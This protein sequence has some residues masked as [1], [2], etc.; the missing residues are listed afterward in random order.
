MEKKN[1]FAVA[2][3]RT[4]K[5][6]LVHICAGLVMLGL[7]ACQG[8][9]DS[10]F[11]KAERPIPDR[12]IKKMKAKGMK[13]SSPILLRI[14]KSENT[15]ELWKQK[16]NGRYG[17][18]ESY[19]I[20]KWSG[21]LGPKHKEGDR[22]APEGFY[23]VG[24]AQLNP[25]SKYHL[26]FN[27]G[28]PNRF[29]RAHGRTG[30]HLM[31]HGACSSAGCYSMTDE[32]VEEIYSFA[33]DAIRGGQDYFQVQAYPFRM[34]AKNLAK[35]ALNPNFEFW[36]MLK[37]GSDQFELTN[38]PPKVDVCEKRYLFNREAVD[39]AKFSPR[40]KCPEVTMPRRLLA[41]YSKKREEEK[42][43]FNKELRRQK[44]RAAL[45]GGPLADIDVDAIS[46]IAKGSEILPPPTPIP[47]PVVK[48]V[49]AETQPAIASADS[50]VTSEPAGQTVSGNEIMAVTAPSKSAP[51][52]GETGITNANPAIPTPAPN[53][54]RIDNGLGPTQQAG[55]Q[56]QPIAGDNGQTVNQ[57]PA[58]LPVPTPAAR[59]QVA[60]P[61][62][63]KKKPWWQRK[64]TKVA[65]DDQPDNGS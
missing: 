49:P 15:L 38:Y 64:Q 39:D 13:P 54:A 30:S 19:E 63:T 61:L 14:Y 58:A 42:L 17:L 59:L 65:T 56:S 18:L 10:V 52:T 2:N 22:Q 55:G 29:D 57:E 6:V 26:S 1:S 20:C 31:V 12:L 24:K 7:S 4:G 44:A 48:P 21:K 41:S 46:V 43:A 23:K 60:E 32:R 45:N 5:M 8:G 16:D 3:S 25:K 36:K 33:R 37:E 53:L 34:S 9:I 51:A 40:A 11:P 27:I 50:P 28:Y 35:N 62:P 47:E